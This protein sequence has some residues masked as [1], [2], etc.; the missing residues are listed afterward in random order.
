M[1]MKDSTQWRIF[2]SNNLAMACI[3]FLI[4]I[5]II[6]F[7]GP[8]F[9]ENP[10]DVYDPRNKYLPPSM[11]HLLGTD[12][13]GRDVLALTVYG[14]KMTLTVGFIAV[15]IAVAIGLIYG[16]IM[17]Y[18]GGMVDNAMMQGVM[19]IGSIPPIALIVIIMGIYGRNIYLVMVL[20]GLITWT[21]IA[22]MT[23]GQFMTFKER[24]FV[25]A[26][27]ACGASTPRVVFLH[28]LPNILA[29]IWV[30]VA[31]LMGNNIVLESTLS[32]LGLGVPF[33][34]ISWG[35]MLAV[36]RE[37]MSDAPWVFIP[38]AILLF[39]TSFSFI[40][41][42]EAMRDAFDPKLRGVSL[43]RVVEAENKKR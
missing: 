33:D 21:G 43:Q 5:Y 34:S 25:Q 18:F 16:S 17:G 41:L 23:R 31:F 24:D 20:I 8:L 36:G 3:I 29:P 32:Y 39:L 22:I 42:G 7:V 28:I 38:S 13:Q 1:S 40:V 37:V 15:I 4:T 35:R 12:K 10:F 14:G 11:E 26:A 19:I 6:S 30:N 27:R 2:R 9:I